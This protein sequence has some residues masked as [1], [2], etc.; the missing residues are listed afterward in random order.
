MQKNIYEAK[1]IVLGTMEEDY[2]KKLKQAKYHVIPK[3]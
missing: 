3:N 1:R 2:Q